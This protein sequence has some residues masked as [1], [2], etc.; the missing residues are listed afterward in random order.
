M[1]A[2]DQAVLAEIK[3]YEA[4]GETGDPRYNELL[5]DHHYVHHVLRAPAA[6]WPD[7]VNRA[8]AGINQQIY[9]SMQGP[10]ELGL[11]GK[12]SDWDRTED[13]ARIDVPTLVIGARHD[14]MDPAFMA[15]MARRLPQGRYLECPDGSHLAMWDDA[16]VYFRG[17]IDFL[18]DL[19]TPKPAR[20]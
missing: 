12:L 8:F 17:L 6:E 13:L 19:A 4:R 16:E 7:P 5:L 1:P 9:V 3:G 10:S 15:A 11:S 14:T 18:R 20:A 2:M